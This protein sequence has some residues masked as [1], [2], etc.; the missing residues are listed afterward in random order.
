MAIYSHPKPPRGTALL[1]RRRKRLDKDAALREAY[2]EVDKR[3]G[4]ICRVTG[5]LTIRG[6]VDPS[7]RREHHHLAGRRVRPEW[8]H[9]PNRIILVCAEA[10][11]LI[12]GGYL[13]VEGTDATG[14]LRFHWHGLEPKD[15]PF[16][17][18]S[19]RMSQQEE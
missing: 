13:T 14:V 12:T 5:R 19:R 17:I 16:E 7:S 18:R 1:E 8:R 15:R 4:R 3:D 10:H 9:D 11:Q 6:A 2:A